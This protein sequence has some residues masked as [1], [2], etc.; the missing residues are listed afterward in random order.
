[1]PRIFGT[2]QTYTCPDTYTCTHIDTQMYS[3]NDTQRL[4]HVCLYT[5]THTYT[6]TNV[7]V[8]NCYFKPTFYSKL[9]K[10]VTSNMKFEDIVT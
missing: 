5:Q 6:Y 2:P 7:H 8:I 3:D 10:I 9:A 1:M 4:M